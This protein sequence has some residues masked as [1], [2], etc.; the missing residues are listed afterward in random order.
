MKIKTHILLWLIFSVCISYA[1]DADSL[2]LALKNATQDTVKLKLLVQLSDACEIEEVEGYVTQAILLCK[3]NLKNVTNERE[4]YVYL[5]HL[6]AA[7]NNKGFIN[8]QFGNIEKALKYYEL[9]LKIQEV[10][11]DK[12]GVA[13]SLNNM[14]YIY[15]NL[16]DVPKALEYMHKA[17]KIQE[18]INDKNG[19]AI[20]LIN[21]GNVSKAHGD[22]S[23]ALEYFIRS[24]KINEELHDNGSIA[25]ALLNIGD[26][27]YTS[28]D[29]LKGL[30]YFN[31][32]LK[33]YEDEGDRYGMSYALINL[34]HIYQK[35]GD[36]DRAFNN[37]NKGLEIQESEKD[38]AG[39]A[40]TLV[41]VTKVL[42]KQGK[43]DKALESGVRGLNLSQELGYPEEI[44]ATSELL[45]RIY[46][47]MGSYK[48]AYEMQVLFKQMT[49]SIVSETNKKAAIQ[50]GFQYEYDKK[51]AADSIKVAAERKVFDAKLKQGKTQRTALYLGIAVIALFSAFMYNRFRVTKKQKQIIEVQKAEVEQQRQ[52]ADERRVVAEDQK[53]IIE[54]KQKEIL[55]SIHYAKRIQQA[56][57][58]SE[59]YITSNF[60]EN[61]KD[62]RDYFIFYQPK[63]IVSGDFYWALS[64]HGKFYIAA[65]DCTGHGVPG[66]FMSLLNISFLNANVIESG[67][68]E[69]AAILNEQRKEIIKALNPT[70]TEN[71]K[72]GM[73][74]VLCAFDLQEN[75]MQFALANNPLWIIR[76]GQL[77][78]IKADKMPVGKYDENINDF[79]AHSMDLQKGDVIYL[80]T[81]GYADQFGGT[82]GKKFKYR[83]LKDLLLANVAKPM[84]EQKE[85]LSK[86]INDWKT[87]V[88]QVDDILIIGVRV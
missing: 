21:I 70:G 10:I 59:E 63:D 40:K 13:I 48:N 54:E 29:I 87:G 69:P 26:I 6:A 62:G 31:K 1:Q 84:A 44:K 35:Q 73:D 57:L 36:F 4:R 64:H 71:S 72:D 27:Y 67:F 81:D 28:G 74:C 76:N 42:Y 55:D 46:A 82:K 41:N 11:K 22:E 19:I 53:H 83:H 43:L 33:L 23:K 17:L 78:E 30:E 3:K 56:M 16:G 66:A 77:I 65:A 61:K 68:K 5:R 88:E 58:T 60:C 47:K 51:A 37:F 45:S 50:K 34:G 86:T 85:M 15:D 2:K 8:D 75:K 49:D 38:K 32:A 79:T 7:F 80:L 9:G 25:V 52:L 24:L 14:A 20:S 39:I 18:E 12:R